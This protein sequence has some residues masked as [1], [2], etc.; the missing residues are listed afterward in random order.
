MN[1]RFPAFAACA[2]VAY[3]L[4]TLA[5]VSPGLTLAIKPLAV[6]S[7]AVGAWQT[8]AR[9]LAVALLVHATGDVAIEVGGILAGIG[10][11]LVG[12]L[13]YLALFWPL[14]PRSNGSDH[15]LSSGL[16]SSIWRRLTVALLAGWAG[17]LV[18]LLLPRLDG[19]LV[20]AVPVYAAALLA[21][22]S[23]ATLSRVTALT[24]LGAVLY[25]ASDSLLAI[26]AFVTSLPARDLAV[27]PTYAAGQILLATGLIDAQQRQTPTED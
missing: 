22:A 14:L 3:L 6:L 7:L 2:A 17:F 24:V 5:G 13:L 9:L 1:P 26:D 11:F 12:H 8:R 18:S 19:P 15:S 27:W 16:G 25:V 23:A 10:P 20:A 21:M 4:L